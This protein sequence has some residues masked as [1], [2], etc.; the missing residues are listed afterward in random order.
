MDPVCYITCKLERALKPL[1]GSNETYRF[2]GYITCKLERALKL[3]M[4]PKK[5]Y[6]SSLYNL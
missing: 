1:R 6:L 5:T 3:N 2:N 4:V